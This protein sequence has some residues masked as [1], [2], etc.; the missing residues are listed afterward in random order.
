MG[1]TRS[2]VNSLS[3][4]VLVQVAS[5]ITSKAAWDA[6]GSMFFSISRSRINNMR[7]ALA[8]TYKKNKK[9]PLILQE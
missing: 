5:L 3:K 4:E 2:W 1:G 7:T 6:I 9:W 8:N